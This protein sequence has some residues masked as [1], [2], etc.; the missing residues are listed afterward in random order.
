MNASTYGSRML[1]EI[2]QLSDSHRA[3]AL[4]RIPSN[5]VVAG[6]VS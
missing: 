2:R 5:S 6:R 3:D 1:R 4:T